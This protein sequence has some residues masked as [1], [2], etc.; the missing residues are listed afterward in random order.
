MAEAC[1]ELGLPV[2]SGN[3]SLYNESQGAAIFPTPIV[4]GLG[5]LD[6]ARKHCGAGFP[7]GG[8]VVVLLGAGELSADQFDLAGSEYLS[9]IHGMIRAAPKLTCP[10]SGGFRICAG[11]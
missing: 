10:W 5:L 1:R 3:V 6:D 2:V 9:I 8:L 7:A 11:V 4:G